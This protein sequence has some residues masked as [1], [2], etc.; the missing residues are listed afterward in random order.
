MKMTPFH[1]ETF[2]A[3]SAA[4]SRFEQ[5][6]MAEIL[7]SLMPVKHPFLERSLRKAYLA[8]LAELTESTAL[9]RPVVA[10]QEILEILQIEDT[11]V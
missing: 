2:L 6:A 7:L 8:Y 3:A 10:L 4:L 11:Y 1:I 5:N 9:G